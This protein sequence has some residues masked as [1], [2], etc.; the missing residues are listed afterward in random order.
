MSV[1]S[2][3]HRRPQLGKEARHL[4]L[5][6]AVEQHQPTLPHGVEKA[7]AGR[8]APFVRRRHLGRRGV[9]LALSRE[10]RAERVAHGRLVATEL[11]VERLLVE[12]F[13][14]VLPTHVHAR[15]VARERLA[16]MAHELLQMRAG[17]L[18]VEPRGDGRRVHHEAVV[19]SHL[20]LGMP[21]EEPGR[22]VHAD[23]RQEQ[24]VRVRR[25]EPTA[26]CVQ[27]IPIRR[28]LR[29]DPP[30]RRAK[31][32]DV[33]ARLPRKARRRGQRFAVGKRTPALLAR[34][35]KRN[36]GRIEERSPVISPDRDA[37]AVL[38]PCDKRDR[39]GARK[40]VR[41][42][43][44]VRQRPRQRDAD[45]VFLARLAIH[46]LHVVN[47]E[48]RRNGWE[49]DPYLGAFRGNGRR[50][51]Q[52]E[53]VLAHLGDESN[54]RPGSIKCARRDR[55]AVHEQPRPAR[56]L[57]HAHRDRSDISGK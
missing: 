26:Y 27:G 14:R 47:P 23:A 56:R 3:P 31:R 8:V 41:M 50:E 40:S 21:R 30:V 11:V 22:R 52:R 45:G 20:H 10:P 19:E 33:H 53:R 42:R 48:L 37:K 32:H 9:R 36:H 55:L 34:R 39:A 57:P 15:E 44:P 13:A 28:L 25:H 24:D 38:V 5:S 6:E 51:R 16:Q 54:G 46:K 18:A 7:A 1:A 12:P 43:A 49:S 4:L 17:G 29:F 35:V 2:A